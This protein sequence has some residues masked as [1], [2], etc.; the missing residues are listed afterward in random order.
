MAIISDAP[1][2]WVV[3]WTIH[4]GTILINRYER[5]AIKWRNAPTNNLSP[6]RQWR[7]WDSLNQVFAEVLGVMLLLATCARPSFDA[8]YGH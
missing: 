4:V 5:V 2:I 6:E 8:K 3:I 1:I 7:R